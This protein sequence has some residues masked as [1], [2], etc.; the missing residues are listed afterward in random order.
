MIDGN[1]ERYYPFHDSAEQKSIQN[2]FNQKLE[3]NKAAG[4]KAA[5][6]GEHGVFTG[7][8]RKNMDNLVVVELQLSPETAKEIKDRVT[9]PIKNIAEGLGIADSV[10]VAGEG[11][12][13]VHVTLHVGK[14]QNITPE[15]QKEIM[16]WLIGDESHLAKTTE[17]LTGLNFNMDTIFNSGRDTSICASSVDGKN[18][19][20][21]LRARRIFEHALA[22]AQEKFSKGEEKIGQHYP[23]YDD[24]FHTT[25]ARFVKKIE[26]PDLEAFNRRVAQVV[27]ANLANHPINIHVQNARVIIATKGVEERKPEILS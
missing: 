24:I 7:F 1:D 17:I 21:A 11:D 3:K 26:Q 2:A 16:E 10:A 27:G 23:R 13:A 19:G 12:Q 20:A 4:D 25:I 6:T 8:E 14:F 9:D 5:A 22:K 18:Q 15:K